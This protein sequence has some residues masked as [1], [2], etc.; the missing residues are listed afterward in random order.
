MSPA[1]TYAWNWARVGAGSEPL[2][3]P[4]AMTAL[5][6]VRMSVAALWSP[7]VA[8]AH[9]VV[10][11]S[12]RLVSAEFAVASPPCAPPPEGGAPWGSVLP[13]PLGGAPPDPLGGVPPVPPPKP[14]RAPPKPPVPPRPPPKPVVDAGPAEAVLPACGVAAVFSAYADEAPVTTT[15][16][17]AAAAT[18][19][20]RSGTSR[21]ITAAT[22]RTS[23]VGRGHAFQ[24]GERPSSSTLQ[25]PVAATAAAS[26]TR[27]A[28]VERCCHNVT[29]PMPTSAA[30]AGA[31]LTV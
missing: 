19:T 31:S 6:L 26:T 21:A 25:K 10:V 9:R 14:P 11:F 4:I 18:A 5:P 23:S 3:P 24:S 7:T 8:A 22:V 16:P 17:A 20:R 1:A 12:S 2:H 29:A 13:D 28:T 15:S 27:A 30:I